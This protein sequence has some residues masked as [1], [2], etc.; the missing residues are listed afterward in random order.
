MYLESRLG[1]FCIFILLK[2][3]LSGEEKV[4]RCV[5]SISFVT[6]LF[7]AFVIWLSSL[8]TMSVPDESYSRSKLN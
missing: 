4:N 2:E 8:L 5:T 3:I 7:M 1:V 6:I